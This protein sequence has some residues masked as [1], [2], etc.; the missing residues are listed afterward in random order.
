[1]PPGFVGQTSGVT[2]EISGA[3]AGSSSSN[4]VHIALGGDLQAP[5]RARAAV[6]R[7]LIDWRLPALVETVALAVSELVTN[8]LVH[9][10]PPVALTVRRGAA[11][12]RIGVHDNS[13]VEPPILAVAEHSAEAVSGRGLG[14]VVQLADAVGCEQVPDDGKIVYASFRTPPVAV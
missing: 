10:L 3:P 11:E 1:L 4:E 9:G 5:R 8:A 7:A 2:E 6:R 14:I 13:P 12:V